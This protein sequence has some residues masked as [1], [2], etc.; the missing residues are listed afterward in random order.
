MTIAEKLQ[1]IAENEQ[2]VFEAGKKSEYDKFWDSY[3]NFGNRTIG[4][5]FA[6][7]AWNDI[8]FKPKYSM[9]GG[10]S[11]NSMFRNSKITDLQ[12]I[13]EHQGVTFDFSACG[14]FANMLQNSTITHIGE[15]N[16]VS[17]S[18]LTNIFYGATKLVTVDLLKIKSGSQTFSGAFQNCTSLSNITI[19]GI[20]GKSMDIHWSTKLSRNSILS[21][22]QACKI[23]VSSITI[24]LPI[25]C[26]DTNTDTLALIESDT[27][28]NT[29]YN[30]ALAL[31][32]TITFA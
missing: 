25:K 26:I 32:Y 4:E 9:G 18:A 30:N 19:E 11:A 10:G 17:A 7:E 31:G 20:I 23:S 21:I 16:T 1:T 28:L 15:I 27:E 29:A 24:T 14:S 3:Q 22:L 2:K 6:S 13:L 5:H 8:T 12:A